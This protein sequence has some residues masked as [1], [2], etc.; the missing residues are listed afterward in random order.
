MARRANGGAC[1]PGPLP[2]DPRPPAGI[3]PAPPR[4]AVVAR[5]FPATLPNLLMMAL[6]GPEP[7]TGAGHLVNLLAVHDAVPNKTMCKKLMELLKLGPKDNGKARPVT[8]QSLCVWI[9]L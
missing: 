9:I 7:E 5:G 6:N 4:A 3:S 1:E 2:G 8:R